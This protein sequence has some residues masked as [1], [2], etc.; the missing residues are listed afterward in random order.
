MEYLVERENAGSIERLISDA[1]AKTVEYAQWPMVGPLLLIDTPFGT[2]REIKESLR[3]AASEF[4][5]ELWDDFGRMME[6]RLTELEDVQTAYESVFQTNGGTY[7]PPSPTLAEV[8]ATATREHNE[9][10]AAD[11]SLERRLMDFV[12]YE[13]MTVIA[14]FSDL[15]EPREYTIANPED[16]TGWADQ[17]FNEHTAR[18]EGERIGGLMRRYLESVIENLARMR[19]A[20]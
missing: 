10:C 13:G 20:S 7:Q 18:Y 6:D 9:I 1:R 4:R 19:E 15:F 14:H 17:V 3:R 8:R 2:K 12:R 5:R 16:T 11:E